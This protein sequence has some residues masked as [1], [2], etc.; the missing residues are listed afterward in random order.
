MSTN[1]QIDSKSKE[2]KTFF[3]QYY[4]VEL[5]YP[6]NEVDAVVTFFTRRGF[7]KTA[8]TSVST[9][10]L[11]QAKLENVPVFEVLDTLKGLDDVQISGVV[12]EVINANRPKTSA[13]GSTNNN[14]IQSLDNRNILP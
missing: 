13:V 10:L 7:T 14:K 2:T 1:L 5:S 11:Q 3:N 8:A 12:A 9:A 6:S 4:N